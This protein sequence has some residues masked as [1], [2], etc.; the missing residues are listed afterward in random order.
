MLSE[1]LVAIEVYGRGGVWRLQPATTETV[2]QL[3]ME[4]DDEGLIGPGRHERNGE[5]TAWRNGYRDRSLD[6][7]LAN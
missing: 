4:A 3:I 7:R 6:T 2:L 1:S 5:R